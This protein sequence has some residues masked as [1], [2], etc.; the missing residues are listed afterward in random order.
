MPNYIT[1]G[2]VQKTS[3]DGKVKKNL[4]DASKALKD[5]G[6]SAEKTSKNTEDLDK[7]TKELKK[8]SGDAVM[9]FFKIQA[10]IQGFETVVR[11]LIPGMEDLSLTGI[12]ATS[13]LAQFT[14]QS[15]KLQKLNIAWPITGLVVGLGALSD[16]FEQGLLKRP[17]SIM[18]KLI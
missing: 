13:S 12:Q 8:S 17:D 7:K 15:E 11:S 5:L 14:I 6:D 9:T 16:A 10:G 4:E 18:F 3:L 1:G 2:G